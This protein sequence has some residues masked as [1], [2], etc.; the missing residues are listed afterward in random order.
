[1]ITNF[2]FL[3]AEEELGQALINQYSQTSFLWVFVLFLFLFWPQF[4]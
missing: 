4:L 2:T 1:M 3:L